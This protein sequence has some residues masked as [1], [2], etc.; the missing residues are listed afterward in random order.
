MNEVIFTYK[1]KRTLNDLVNQFIDVIVARRIGSRSREF[2]LVRG[3]K[4]AI[5]ASDYIGI[6]INQYGFFDAANLAIVFSFL[7]PILDEI[8]NDAALDI[9]ANIGNH[10]IYFSKYFCSILSFE[11]HPKIFDLLTFNSKMVN[12]VIAYNFGLGD[13]K[14][15]LELNENWE[16]MGSSSIKHHSNGDDRKVNINIRRLDD[17]ELGSN[18]IS[19]IK[20]DVEGFES[21]VIRGGLA[22]INKYQPIIILEQLE[23]EFIDGSTDALELLKKEGYVFCWHQSWAASRGWLARRINTVRNILLGGTYDYNFLTGNMPPKATYGMIIAVPA[24]FQSQLLLSPKLVV[25]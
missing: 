15:T 9:G 19:L 14:K 24:R 2:N 22:T 17:I 5:F 23:S 7:T 6:H 8:K 13:E 3:G 25:Q 21:N 4:M 11:P 18:G 12:N 16:N 20:I 1:K 10:S